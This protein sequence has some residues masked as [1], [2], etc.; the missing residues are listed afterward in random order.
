MNLLVFFKMW[1]P[2]SIAMNPHFF[3]PGF[4]KVLHPEF[5]DFYDLIIFLK[6]WIHLYIGMYPHALAITEYIEMNPHF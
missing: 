4:Y 3:R 2:L 1:I 6:I 5:L